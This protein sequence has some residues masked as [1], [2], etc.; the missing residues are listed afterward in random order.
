MQPILPYTRMLAK[1]FSEGIREVSNN[2]NKF[3]YFRLIFSLFLFIIIAL[4]ILN[5]LP[6]VQNLGAFVRAILLTLCTG[7]FF[8]ITIPILFGFVGRIPF[9]LAMILG[10]GL[11]FLLYKKLY[12]KILFLFSSL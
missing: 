7:S 5:E 11:T 1:Q 10:G 12:L 4:M 6:F 8:A 3:V 2:D 9:L